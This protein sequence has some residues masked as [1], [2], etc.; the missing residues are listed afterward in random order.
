M[1]S[2]TSSSSA[3]D[4]DDELNQDGQIFMD[5]DDITDESSYIEASS[6]I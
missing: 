3:D 5:N 2:K 4:E 6:E 1:S